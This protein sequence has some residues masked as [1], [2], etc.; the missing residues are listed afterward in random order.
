MSVGRMLSQLDG[1]QSVAKP[2]SFTFKGLKTVFLRLPGN[3]SRDTALEARMSKL[4][5]LL[6]ERDEFGFRRGKDN[7]G[8]LCNG[9]V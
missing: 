6:V 7:L 1:G 5:S 4:R 3:E 9:G 8:F 2:E